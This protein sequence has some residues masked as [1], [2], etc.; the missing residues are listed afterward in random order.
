MN[1]AC[2][3]FLAGLGLLGGAGQALAQTAADRIVEWVETA[4]ASD[5]S[6]IALGYPVPIPVDTPLPFA[7]FRSYA[8]LHARHQDLA[9]TTPWVH[10]VELGS[11][12]QGRTIWL[13]Q[14][15]DADKSTPTGRPE[16]AML[17]NGGIH[18]REWQTPEVA[19]GIIELL[20]LGPADDPLLAY[21]RENA[22]ILVIPVM[23]IDGFLQTQ[24]YP[25]HNWLG[26]DPDDPESS[27]RDG[28]MRR[29]NMRDADENLQT[30]NDH[31][32]GVDL[33]RNNPPFWATNPSRSSGFFGSLVYHGDH[34]HSEPETRVLD[35]AAALGPADQLDMYTDLHSFSQVHLW[36]RNNYGRLAAQTEGLL[37]VFS[38][39]HAGF[40]A[41]KW[42]DFDTAGNVPRN[43]GIGTTDEH[44]T[45]HYRVPA[46]T[47]EVEPTIG[48]PYHAPLP[49]GGADYGGLGRNVH[50]GFI[51]PESEVERVRTEMAQ[52]FAVAYYHQSGP[53]A[54]AAM[55]LTDA[56]TGAVVFEAEWDP[57]DQ[58]QRVLH[59]YQPQPLQL[60]RD[61]LAWFAWDKPMRWRS[62]GDVSV[63]PGQPASTLDLEQRATVDGNDLEV[64][65]LSPAWL[66]QPG[67]APNGFL[68]YRDDAI[69]YAFRIE[70]SETNRALVDGSVAA[71][72]ETEIFDMTG[73]RNDA[74]PATVAHWSAGAWSGYENSAGEDGGDAGGVD[75]TIS[76]ELTSESLGDPFVIEAGT[77]AAWFDIDR[78]G[79]GFM[80][81][82]L[83]DDRAV[84]YWFTY[85][86]EGG[87]DWYVA[88]GKIRGNRILFPELLRV[89]GGEFGP[90]FDPGRVERTA[91]GS[92]S[93]IWSS[94]DSGSMH[95]RIDRDGGSLR[96]GRM[97]L[98]R[99]SSLQGLECGQAP[100]PADSP[101]G[102][103]SG[104]WYD[105]AH[106]G[107]GYVL[108]VLADGRALVYWFSFDSA[109]ARRWFFGTGEVEGSRLVFDEMFTTLGPG[110]GAAFDPASLEL[111]D[112]GALMMDL[113]C[114][115][116][117][118][119]FTPRKA[120]FPAGSLQLVRLSQ[121]RGLPCAD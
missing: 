109:G 25:R 38:R 72:V 53:P 70:A 81:E 48:Q 95:W 22:N 35:V 90:G 77:S 103:L 94:C 49:G 121:L 52:S 32:R 34:S 97:N 63:L 117:V 108:E 114:A 76:F 21:L 68:R 43:R 64:S 36:V 96:Q 13:Y 58:R 51:L 111:R 67:E 107:E 85:D 30:Q 2:A 84:M 87:Q 27:P 115:S 74:N 56:A 4:P 101:A 83:D 92:A 112:W 98:T 82:I 7:G 106:S 33:N 42:Y 5:N 14:L 41:G 26:T 10:P 78:N 104:S 50:D 73:R 12:I 75:S 89:S 9:M 8:G 119:D 15:G 118:A 79:E 39:H 61:Y 1:R 86:T 20:A 3:L 18:A 62:N 46:W 47:L 57:E 91:V 24:R 19:T 120:G 45:H 16:Q 93:F 88:E 69:A 71:T 55:R 31:L 6:R 116:G 105:P 66:D 37:R 60:G 99:L 65:V 17:T 28:R 80:L 113:S 23:N 29:K 40:A 54:L 110:F 44:F 100:A 102:G 11:T 59:R